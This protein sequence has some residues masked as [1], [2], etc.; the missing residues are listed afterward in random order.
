MS[1]RFFK[2]CLQLEVEIRFVRYLGLV[3]MML[4]LVVFKGA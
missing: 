3:L 4:L 1:L 2:A